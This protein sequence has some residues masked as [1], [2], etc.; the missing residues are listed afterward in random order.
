MQS[1]QIITEC[2]VHIQYIQIKQATCIFQLHHDIKSLII[3]EAEL[4][5]CFKCLSNSVN[6]QISIEGGEKLSSKMCFRESYILKRAK[7]SPCNVCCQN[8]K[9]ITQ[10]YR[11]IDQEKPIMWTSEIKR[12]NQN[13]S[14]KNLSSPL[15]TQISGKYLKHLVTE[16]MLRQ[17]PCK[18]IKQIENVVTTSFLIETII[19]VRYSKVAN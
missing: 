8:N 17:L 14:S 5:T 11:T 1:V 4:N 19:M 13:N 15:P 3:I 10:S 16:K 18:T 7:C 6:I 2:F 9:M 12:S